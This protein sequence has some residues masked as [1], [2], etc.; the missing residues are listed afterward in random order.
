MRLCGVLSESLFRERA[1]SWPY[2]RKL[3]ASAMRGLGRA[4]EGCTGRSC[5]SRASP[6]IE[7]RQRLSWQVHLKIRLA[8]NGTRAE[9]PAARMP[10]RS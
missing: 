8:R 2:T 4:P 9:H 10:S 3:R 1:P 7:T 5:K 6:R